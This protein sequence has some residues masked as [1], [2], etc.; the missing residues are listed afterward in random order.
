ML[1]LN[2]ASGII[3]LGFAMY[4]H[5]HDPEMFDWWALCTLLFWI[6]MWG[7]K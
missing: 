7:S 5:T 6:N 2:L 4:S 3:C 1:F